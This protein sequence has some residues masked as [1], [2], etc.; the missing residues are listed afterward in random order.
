MNKKELK[1]MIR[2][3]FENYK[4]KDFKIKIYHILTRNLKLDIRNAIITS[5][6]YLYYKNKDKNVLEYIKCIF[7][8][9]KQSRYIKYHMLD[10]E[11]NV[12]E[13]LTIYHPNI[14]ISPKAKLGNNVKL[15]GANCIG[16]NGF[17]DKAPT[18]GNNVDI[19][20]GAVIIGDIE[21]ADDIIIGAN[22]LV[23][24]S[25]LEKGVVI[26]GVPAKI[27]KK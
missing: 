2:K 5:R 10:I 4:E 3:D 24:K 20:Y 16:N 6:K 15:H 14:I 23:N 26:A 12:G 21:I 7:Y 13:N 22:A 1:E 17:I 9:I 25:F 8:G 27:I 11:G 18:I 19:G